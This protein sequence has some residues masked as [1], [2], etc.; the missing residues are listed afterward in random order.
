MRIL[1]LAQFYPPTLGG[2]EHQVRHLSR[3]L[4]RRD[5][6]VAVATFWRKGLPEFEVDSGVEIYRIPSTVQRMAGLF[7]DSERR[8]APPFPDPEAMLALG[9][10]ITHYQPDIVH[11]HNWL[12]HSFL[13]LKFWSGAKLILT[14]HDYSLLCT[15]KRL[16]YR[17]VP[18][19][20]PALNQ[21]L[22]CACSHYGA[23]KG[24]A[25][26]LGHWAMQAVE[27]KTV[28]LFLPVSQAVAVGNGLLAHETPYQVVPNFLPD[29]L[30]LRQTDASNFLDQLP[31]EDFLLFV[32]DLGHDKGLNVLLK[33]YA[34]LSTAPPLVLIGRAY[35]DTPTQF[36]ANVHVFKSWPHYAVM[37][38]W[39]RS[40][41]ALAPSVWPEPF[42]L[43]VIE[44]MANARPVIASR[45][46]GLVDIVVDEE[47]GLLV[48]AGDVASLR[49][50]L[51]RLLADPTLRTR[52]GEAGKRRFSQFQASH[53]VPMVEQIY[54]NLLRSDTYQQSIP[55]PK[56]WASTDC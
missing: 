43:V 21:C 52:L 16:M 45:T 13:P 47:T 37:Q 27:R 53:V 50:A 8:H 39:Q 24:I 29:D 49:Q 48:P 34:G 18:C 56:E 6:A 30:N 25:S 42:G 23:T 36:P 19:A 7:S 51:V 31:K 46:G 41:I 44:A 11:A 32:G 33:A 14:L 22:A 1:M 26:V 35:G 17:G 15:Q 5:H 28:D 9:K 4:A 55:G 12:V 20:G 38:A 54:Q 10:L 3:E 2:E 40:L